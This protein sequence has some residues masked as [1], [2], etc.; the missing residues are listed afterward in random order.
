MT[1]CN[2]KS[3]VCKGVLYDNLLLAAW[4][5]ERATW[6]PQ[7]F[8]GTLVRGWGGGGAPCDE[9]S[10]VGFV[11]DAV[12]PGKITTHIH[13]LHFSETTEWGQ[14][15]HLLTRKRLQPSIFPHLSSAAPSNSSPDKSWDRP[16]G[17]SNTRAQNS[18]E[19]QD[20]E[21]GRGDLLNRPLGLGFDGK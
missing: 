9:S 12:I 13:K 4:Q 2:C 1:C 10:V 18:K 19:Q 8:P 20:W 14:R 16:L 5:W 17:L 21:R 15:Q 3:P 6:D 11:T 7:V